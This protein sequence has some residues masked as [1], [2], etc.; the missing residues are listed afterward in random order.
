M[1]SPARIAVITDIHHGQHFVTKRGDRALDLMADF[2]TFVR[3]QGVDHVLD[4]GDRISDVDHD[5]DLRLEADVAET[6]AAIDTPISHVCGNHDVA[7]LTMEE[8]EQIFDRPMGHRTV[9]VGGWRIV[10]WGADATTLRS[11]S[12]TGFVLREADLIW[13]ATTVQQADRPLLVVTHIPFSGDT[14]FGNYYFEN[15]PTLATYPN[16]HRIRAALGLARV[17]V[18]ALTGHVHRNTFFALDGTTYLTQ[19]SL[20]ESFTTQGEPAAAMGIIE[21]GDDDNW[22]V[23]GR[24]PI[25]MRFTPTSRRWTPPLPRFDDSP[26]L[27][28]RRDRKAETD[29]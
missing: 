17:P 13:L 15:N 1:T 23:W 7:L 9:D 22:Q 14:Q 6:F 11:P 24:D 18:V 27:K 16:N 20:T 3:K 4:L 8:N 10:V 28:A 29:V 19:Q 26:E 5:T 2:G 25:Q 12:Y 21:L